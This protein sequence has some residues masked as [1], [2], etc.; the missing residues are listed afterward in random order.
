MFIIGGQR[1][2]W[3]NM[4]MAMRGLMWFFTTKLYFYWHGQSSINGQGCGH[5][6]I[7]RLSMRHSQMARLH[8]EST[9]YVNDWRVVRWVH[10][11]ENLVPRTKGEGAL[12]MVVDFVSADYGWLTSPDGPERA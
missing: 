6:I 4:L 7:K 11:G 5:Q 12:L 2:H 1:S 10:K 8:D 9:F 3:G